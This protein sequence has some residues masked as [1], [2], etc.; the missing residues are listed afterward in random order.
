MKI[1]CA[2][3]QSKNGVNSYVFFSPISVKQKWGNYGML[4]SSI[5]FKWEIFAQAN[6]NIKKVKKIKILFLSLKA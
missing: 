6:K 5:S 1:W 4:S 3:A 2:L